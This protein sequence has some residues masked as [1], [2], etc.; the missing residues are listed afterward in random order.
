MVI[1]RG[2]WKFHFFSDT[3]IK[4]FVL[5]ILTQQGPA[6]FKHLHINFDGFQKFLNFLITTLE[7]PGL[8]IYNCTRTIFY[9]AGNFINYCS[10][11]LWCYI[12]T[13]DSIVLLLLDPTNNFSNIPIN[14][15]SQI[16]GHSSDTVQPASHPT[17]KPN[18]WEKQEVH[19]V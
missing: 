6:P 13:P 18:R 11:F 10:G 16:M 5:K 3:I 9:E 4:Y 14:L 17:W 15:L 12:F 8:F 2:S 19:P 1:E 7:E